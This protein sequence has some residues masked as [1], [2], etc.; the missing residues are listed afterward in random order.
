MI[1]NSVSN[2]MK[3]IFFLVVCII[4]TG[5]APIFAQK[6]SDPVQVTDLLQV[7]AITAVKLSNDG[8]RAAYTVTSVIPDEKNPDD[9]VYQTQIWVLNTETSV[10]SQVSFAKEGASQPA[11]SPDGNILAFVRST[12][13]KSQIFL[14]NLVTGGEPRQLTRSKYGANN[15]VWSPDGSKLVYNSSMTIGNMRM[16]QY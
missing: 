8:K 10:S 14:L 7:K 3:R 1:M 2:N 6:G 15:P 12:E 13:G 9:F 16:I 4:C 11:W 5:A